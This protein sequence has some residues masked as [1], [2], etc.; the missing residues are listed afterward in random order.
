MISVEYLK[1]MINPKDLAIKTLGTPFISKRNANWYKSPFRAEERTASFEVTD[2]AFHDFGTGEHYD[3]ISFMRKLNN[4]SFKQAIEYLANLYGLVDNEYK[5][6]RV[7]EFLAK[8]R[9]EKRQYQ[10]RVEKWFVDFMSYIEDLWDENEACI[11]Y[12]QDYP[13]TLS[14]L[15]LR[16]V[17]LGQI[18]EEILTVST[19]Q[20]KE[21]LRNQVTKEGLPEWARYNKGYGLIHAS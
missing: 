10:E 14:I 21:S 16:Q 8:Q 20:E 19:F 15:Y 2:Y 17:Y 9:L 3:I 18:R 7:E 5:S 13:D 4:C 12:L 11:K 6:R 1:K